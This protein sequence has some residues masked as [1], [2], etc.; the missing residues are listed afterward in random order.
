MPIRVSL[1]SRTAA[2]LIALVLGTACVDSATTPVTP[3]EVAGVYTLAAV[4]GRGPAT[5]TFVLTAEGAATRSVKYAASGSTV[6]SV[7][8]GAYTLD[9]DRGIFFTFSESAVSSY[10]WPVRGEWSG[11]SFAISYPDPADGPN[12]V[13]TYRRLP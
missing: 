13:E 3:S 1:R 6:E 2:L 11:S 10:M 8:T 9:G 12:I 7:M 5:G 4:S